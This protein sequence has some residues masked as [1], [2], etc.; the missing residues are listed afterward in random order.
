MPGGLEAERLCAIILILWPLAIKRYCQAFAPNSG[1]RCA[2]APIGTQ[3]CLCLVVSHQMGRQLIVPMK[4]S[5]FL[6]TIAFLLG[7]SQGDKPRRLITMVGMG[8][9]GSRKSS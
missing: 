9:E 5:S 1:H 2:H 4:T 3:G 6:S 7:L 8:P